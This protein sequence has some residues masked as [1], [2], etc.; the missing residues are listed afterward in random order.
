MTSLAPVSGPAVATVAALLLAALS[1]APAAAAPS[2]GDERARIRLVLVPSDDDA[3]VDVSG[4]SFGLIADRVRSVAGLQFGL[5]FLDATRSLTGLQLSLGFNFVDGQLRGGQLAGLANFST[6]T[7]GWQVGIGMNR[8]DNLEGFQGG[9]AN[10]ADDGRGLQ[11]G[12][13]NGA[14]R[15]LGGR[16]GV[17]N[18][19]EEF[20][21]AEV[22][23]L[24][25]GGSLK[26]FQVGLMNLP[27]L[28]LASDCANLHRD[29]SGAS[30]GAVNVAHAMSGFDL[31]LLNV[32]AE[33]RGLHVG[34]V[35]LIWNDEGESLALVSLTRTG[36]HELAL[37]ATD[38]M[39]LNADLK[40][41]SR[42]LF[43]VIT[44]SLQPGHVPPADSK[45]IPSDTR[46]IAI[47]LGLGW[48]FPIDWRRLTFLELQL[49]VNRLRGDSADLLHDGPSFYTLRLT[50]AVR[51]TD[52]LSLLAGVG[53]GLTTSA[54][55]DQPSLGHL[56]TSWQQSDTAFRLF[57]GVILGL[58]L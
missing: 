40:L 1:P 9:F 42:H 53:L 19:S 4:F 57:P 26:G 44:G 2:T 45:Q 18:G 27:C 5:V 49:T 28:P 7:R 25:F 6:V 32:A 8:T 10:S 13:L 16:I 21:G 46:R 24:N 52:H 3:S 15:F 43:T 58:Q 17:V 11:V 37:Y 12:I 23:L 47:G 34:L 31:A 54:T 51:L 20:E 38:T 30:V 55:T 14:L 29:I 41:G 22:G 50:G 56:A 36:I 33:G 35:N 39:L 48:R